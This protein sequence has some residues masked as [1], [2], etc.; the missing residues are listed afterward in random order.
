MRVTTEIRWNDKIRYCNDILA[1]NDISRAVIGFAILADR[2]L[3][4]DFPF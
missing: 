2:I 4:F 1:Y 3:I